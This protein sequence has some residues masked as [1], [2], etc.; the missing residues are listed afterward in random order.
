MNREQYLKE[1]ASLMNE[2]QKLL[3]EGKL[4]ESAAKA[5]EVKALDEKYEAIAKA[6]ANLNAL[7]DRNMSTGMQAA[8]VAS[9]GASVVATMGAETHVSDLYDSA[10]YK[11]AFQAYVLSG[12]PIPAN[13]QNANETTKTTDAAAM[14]PSTTLQKIYEKMERLGMV[15]PLVTQTGYKGGLSVPTSTVKPVATWV[16]EGAGSDKQ[17]TTTGSITFAYHKLRCA[18]SM[19]YEM[20]NMAYPMFETMFVNAVSNAMI[21]AKETAIINGSGVGQPKGILKE[22]PVKALTVAKGAS[23]TY[24]QLCEAEGAE[25]SDSAV[26]AMTKSTFM[27]QV[28]GMVDANGQ[29]VARVNYG[30]SGKPEYT[31]MGRPVVLLNSDYIASWSAAPAEAA[32]IAFLYDF[33]DYIFN[34][35]VAMLVKRYYDEDV[36]DTVTKAI[37]VCDGKSVRND[38][39]VTISTSAT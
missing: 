13:L 20:D 22:T 11:K 3:D 39:L 19:T 12:T 33:A 26:W 15:M 29:P 17:K 32:V 28:Q 14:I 31:I 24:K 1:R 23:I 16:A 4:E 18:V 10:E 38:S 35:G 6:Q 34:S 9:T 7:Q 5:A 21:K 27:N 8:A 36:D 37:E 30:V 2:A 25:E